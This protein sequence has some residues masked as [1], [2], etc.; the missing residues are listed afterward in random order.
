MRSL[1]LTILLA[2]AA[3]LSAQPIPPDPGKYAAAVAPLLTTTWGQ[4]APFYNLCPERATSAGEQKHCPAG[5]VA[6][7]LAQIM[8]YWNYPEQGQ[9]SNSYKLFLT[10]IT[11]SA[12]FG[13]TRYDW[14]NMRDSYVSLGSYHRYTDEEAD[15]VA[16]LM[17]HCG[18][19]VG[20][21]YQLT[22]SS[23]LAYGNIPRDLTDYFRYEAEGLRY[24]TRSSYTKEEWMDMIFTELSAGRPVFY[25]GNSPKEGGHAFVLDGYDAAGRVHINWGWRGTSNDY[26]DIDL[27]TADTDNDYCNKQSMVI[28]IR[29]PQESAIAAAPSAAESAVGDVYDLNGRRT[30]ALRRGVNIVRYHDG[31]TRV[32]IKK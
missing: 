8:K 14:P 3:A 24:V 29:P 21:I 13:S 11:V 17:Y 12:D 25:T 19:A 1:L 4:N 9:G 20:T 30:G 2:C 10:D 27:L 18:V 15:A 28:G 16:T 26:Y 6:C 31:K 5:C 23:A 32:V 22:G 7:A